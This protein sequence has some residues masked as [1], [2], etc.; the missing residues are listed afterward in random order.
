MTV[1]LWNADKKKLSSI[2]FEH[3]LLL[4][5]AG[6]IFVLKEQKISRSWNQSPTWRIKLPFSMD[7][8]ILASWSIWIIRNN[9]IFKNQEARWT[10]WKA[11][12]MNELRMLA[13]RMKKK[14]LD[15]F[16]DWLHTV[17]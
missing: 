17:T 9:K 4:R 10:S 2:Y 7:I 14:F 5:N 3:V 12:Y 15:Q 8:I 6:I 1:L 11:I 13:F 16:V